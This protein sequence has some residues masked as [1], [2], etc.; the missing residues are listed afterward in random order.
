VFFEEEDDLVYSDGMEGHAP[1]R[2]GFTLFAPCVRRQINLVSCILF[3]TFQGEISG[4][5]LF[6]T[7]CW[8][9]VLY[10]SVVFAHM[11]CS[12]KSKLKFS[13]GFNGVP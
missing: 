1:K 5:D 2:I 12:V 11:E 10:V 8:L 13:T 6:S 9:I 7:L 4:V 3:Q